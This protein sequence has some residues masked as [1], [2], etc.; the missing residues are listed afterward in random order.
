MIPPVSRLKDPLM[1]AVPAALLRAAEKA[2][3]L[4][5][6]TGTPFVSRICGQDEMKAESLP[7]SDLQTEKDAG[8]Q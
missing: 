1:Q 2:R 4:A 7:Q 8:N 3:R 5:E 6:Q